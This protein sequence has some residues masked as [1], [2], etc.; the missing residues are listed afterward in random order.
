MERTKF[1]EED[2]IINKIKE[3]IQRGIKWVE[4]KGYV[5]NNPLQCV[6]GREEESIV[7]TPGGEMGQFLIMAATIEK[8][9]GV[10]LSVEEVQDLFSKYLDWSG[11]FYMHSDGHMLSRIEKAL[12]G[13]DRFGAYFRENKN[14][15]VEGTIEGLIRMPPVGLREPLLEHLVDTVNLGC[16]HIYLIREHQDQYLVRRELV[17]VV[18]G[19]YYKHL[20]SGDYVKW[21]VLSGEHEERGVVDIIVEEENNE[22][23]AV[24]SPNSFGVQVFVN[25]PQVSKL[26]MAH[27]FEFVEKYVGDGVNINED[28]YI[29]EVEALGGKHV[30][31]TLGYLAKG[32][33]IYNCYVSKEDGVRLEKVGIVG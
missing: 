6:D 30:G 10:E 22:E 32:L 23:V 12:I 7:G 14:T 17:D 2:S 8:M 16:G 31:L 19:E 11:H 13:D 3:K 4:R 26:Y 27:I 18:I 28:E 25:H 5:E 21:V 15:S 20:W 33:P 24:V 9:K 29:R 1:M